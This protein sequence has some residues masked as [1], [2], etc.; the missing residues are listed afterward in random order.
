[1]IATEGVL[2]GLLLTLLALPEAMT[3]DIVVAPCV[4]VVFTM[5]WLLNVVWLETRVVGAATVVGSGVVDDDVSTM[6]GCSVLAAT[7][8]YR[9]EGASVERASVH[10][11]GVEVVMAEVV[12]VLTSKKTPGVALGL[13]IEV[14]ASSL[15][16]PLSESEVSSEPESESLLEP[17]STAV[18]IS[19]V[20]ASV[21]SPDW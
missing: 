17:L 2:E 10:G 14:V 9:V 1:M 11:K 21:V 18:T 8:E 7:I 6:V 3:S 20:L 4:A 13:A 12:V 5:I 15:A 19:P 16:D